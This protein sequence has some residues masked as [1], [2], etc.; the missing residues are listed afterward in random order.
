MDTEVVMS[1]RSAAAVS[2]LVDRVGSGDQNA[3]SEL[4]PV[5]YDELR[6]L[7][8]RYVGREHAAR[9]IQAT[10]LVHAAIQSGRDFC[11]EESDA[12]VDT[13]GGL[14]L[15]AAAVIGIRGD[16]R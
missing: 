6:R 7:A 8:R 4:I 10:D 16:C 5:V 2:Q 14:A 1:P 3:V 11:P 13:H 12:P 9:S 15:C